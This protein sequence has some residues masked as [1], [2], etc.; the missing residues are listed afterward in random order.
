MESFDE[1]MISRINIDYKFVIGNLINTLQTPL[2]LNQQFVKV[3]V[4]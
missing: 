1:D 2:Q 4:I 3:K